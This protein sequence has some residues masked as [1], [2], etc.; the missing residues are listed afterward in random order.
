MQLPSLVQPRRL[1]GG[2]VFDFSREVA[3]MAIINRT[4][5][6]F[7]D[8]GATFELDAAVASA[9]QATSDGADWVDIGGAKFA[10]G[11][12]I[13]IAEEI[14]RVVPVVEALRGAGVVISVDTFHAEVAAAAIAAGAHVINDTT[15]VHDP[16]LAEVVAGS[17]ATLVI[18]HS[19]AKPRMPYPA[20]RYDDVVGEVAAFLRER[21][22]RAESYGVPLERIVIDPGHDLNKNT[23]H[24]LE[25]TR[26]LNEI[27]A[28]GLPTL[29]AISNKDF[30][31]ETLNR[32]RGARVDGSLAAAVFCILQGAR[33]VRMHNVPAAVDA[34]RMTEA[35][36]GFRAPAFLRH[37]ME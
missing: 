15:G 19:L 36:L 26:R 17:E 22:A 2:R 21:V 8:R 3:V 31:G 32:E 35:I 11:P 4:P 29:A 9:R 30:I 10:P 27:V 16:A 20:P 28:I 24:S 5:D 23:L 6:S 14:D 18:T 13:P 25:L 37:N 7:Y 12:A 1:I 33:I 34:V